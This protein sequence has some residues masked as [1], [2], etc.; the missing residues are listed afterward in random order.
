M[1]PPW[2]SEARSGKMGP[3][4]KDTGKESKCKHFNWFMSSEVP[5]RICLVTAD[6]VCAH[7]VGCLSHPPVGCWDHQE[8]RL[9]LRGSQGFKGWPGRMG[10]TGYLRGSGTGGPQPHQWKEKSGQPE[11]RW[12]LYGPK[13]RT[14][15]LA[16]CSPSDSVRFCPHP[17]HCRLAVLGC[18]FPVPMWQQQWRRQ[19]TYFIWQYRYM[20]TIMAA[21]W[22][23]RN[24]ER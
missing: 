11:T 12:P 19:Q 9:G 14:A 3:S 1:P 22:W 20:D 23:G 2:E 15:R 4:P 10:R 7:A 16:H 6:F 18:L 8:P 13:S 21:S 17:D 5:P 24:R